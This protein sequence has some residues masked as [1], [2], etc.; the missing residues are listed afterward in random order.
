MHPEGKIPGPLYLGDHRA[1]L[2]EKG[3]RWAERDHGWVRAVR[4]RKYCAA[5]IKE[6]TV[7]HRQAQRKV[8]Y[9]LAVRQATIC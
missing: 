8:V 9:L 2:Y 7:A 5:V 3:Y 1:V 4:G 6:E